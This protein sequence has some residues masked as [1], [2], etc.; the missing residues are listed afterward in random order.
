MREVD[1]SDH[2]LPDAART[3]GTF[4]G[5]RVIPHEFPGQSS[6]LIDSP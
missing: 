1:I 2:C 5:L 6:F 3:G 4:S